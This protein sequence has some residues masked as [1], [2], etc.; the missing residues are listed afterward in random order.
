[1]LSFLIAVSAFLGPRIFRSQMD[2]H[3]SVSF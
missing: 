2:V 1:M 3:M